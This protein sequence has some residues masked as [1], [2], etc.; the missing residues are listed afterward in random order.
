MISIV[1]VTGLLGY[2]LLKLTMS[3]S[4]FIGAVLS[5]SSTTVVLK[6]LMEKH[7]LNSSIGQVMLGLLIVQDL[8]LS[9]L[10][11]IISLARS[12]ADALL[13][14]ILVHILKFAFLATIVTCCAFLWPRILRLLDNSTHDLFLL[15][16][17]AMCILLTVIADR[18]IGSAEVGSFLAGILI[19][20]SPTASPEL[21][22]RSLRLF[23]PIR[24][25]F[26][27]LFFSSIGMLL[28]PHFI[29]DNWLEILLLVT[30]TI[31]LKTLVAFVV[32]RIF[33]LTSS[34]SL[35]VGLCLSQVGE[36]AFIL[37]SQGLRASLITRDD[38]M[39]LLGVTAVRYNTQQQ[40]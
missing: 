27:A 30:V 26:G 12:P 25:M 13:H 17:V 14:D 7:E 38:Y 24:D 16:L 23:E 39:L 40:Q 11:S 36:F 31:A 2:S 5:M 37:A 10:L 3:K 33:G 35:H 22:K 15:G 8:F 20:S 29:L 1:L 19:S 6:A 32:V 18:I 34:N 4:L 21:T 9:L 28:N